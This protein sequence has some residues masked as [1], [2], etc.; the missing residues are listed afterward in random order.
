MMSTMRSGAIL[1]TLLGALI[2]TPAR[3]EDNDPLREKALKL[4][5]TTGTAPLEG[6]L[7]QLVKDEAGTKKLVE[8]AV[9][10]AKEKPQPFNY[11]AAFILARAAHAVKEYESAKVFYKIASTDAL[12]LQ[13][14]NKIIQVYDGLIDLF[15][16]N[17]K[18]DDAIKA[19]REF[20]EID[21]S[22]R[23]S[24]INRIKPFVMERMIQALAKQG[25]TDE[26][27]K[28]TDELVEADGDGWY[29]VRLKAEVYREAGKF[30]DA[31]KWFEDT[32]G[33]L[34]KIKDIE[35]E[36]RERFMRGVRYALSGVYVDMNKIDKAAEQL[37]A[38]LKQYPDNATFMNDLGFIWA[39]H[40]MKLDESEKLIRKAIEQD[41][42]DRKKIDDLP[43]DEDKDNA[44]YLDSLG[45]V[46]F[47]KKD[48]K[49]AKKHLEDAIKQKEGQHIEI[50]DHL[51]DV[52]MALGETKEAIKVWEEALKKEDLSRR[53][54]E[55]RV[56]IEKKFK[57][58]QE[59][60]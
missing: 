41:R 24:P 14:A 31:A 17:K 25:K 20:L 38:L 4:N 5:E 12:K 10:M 51:A 3:A 26:A 52:H 58:A 42:K 43:P 44:A 53:E 27:L 54:K 16:E 59:S 49:E 60:K 50:L 46:L 21:S 7:R 55:R 39:D 22:D 34:K 2:V 6:E 47:K 1:A 28:M 36:R 45:W 57:K 37:Q 40:D 13:S 18:F 23:T 56:D 19:C 29:F 15:Y 8:V 33:R 35:E 32:L 30:E 11:T 9:K 48:F